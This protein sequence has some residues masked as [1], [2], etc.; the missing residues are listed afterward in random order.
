MSVCQEGKAEKLRPGNPKDLR[1]AGRGKKSE[2][3]DVQKREG[4]VRLEQVSIDD[5]IEAA[6]LMQKLVG[7]GRRYA[8]RA[9][10]KLR[11][12]KQRQL[13]KIFDA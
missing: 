2:K 8:Q 11:V 10:D 9:G 5:E 3:S 1:G 12:E 13:V 4:D 7:A 6:I